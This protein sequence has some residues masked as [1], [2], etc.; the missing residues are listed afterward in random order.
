ML[1]EWDRH[2]GR[3]EDRF[4]PPPEVL[5]HAATLFRRASRVPGVTVTRSRASALAAVSLVHAMRT[6]GG[7]HAIEQH[8]LHQLATTPRA[9]NRAFTFLAATVLEEHE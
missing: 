7:S 1:R 5:A 4:R 3:L 2:V 8:V 9:M 6:A